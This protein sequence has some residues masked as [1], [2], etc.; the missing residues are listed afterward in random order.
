MWILNWVDQVALLIAPKIAMTK[1][2]RPKLYLQTSL[3]EELHET[4]AIEE[5]E[6]DSRG[7]LTSHELLI[8]TEILV[9]RLCSW[10][11]V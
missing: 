8:L 4:Q 10:K 11:K 7:D 6:W 3:F 9:R 5:S 2:L 1:E